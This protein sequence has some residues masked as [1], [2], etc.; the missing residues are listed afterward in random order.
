MHACSYIVDL[1]VGSHTNANVCLVC[2][3][4]AA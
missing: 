3:T 2:S 4:Y 1:N